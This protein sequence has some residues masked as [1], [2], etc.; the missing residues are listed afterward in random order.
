MADTDQ[1]V[2]ADAEVFQGDRLVGKVTA[3][4]YSPIL[5]Q[6]LALVQ[7]EPGLATPGTKVEVKGEN[8]SC[9]ATVQELPFY[10]PS[11]GKRAQ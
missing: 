9:S 2:D 3:P 11:K 6:S 7:I 1:A 4:N 10:D 5:K 8:T